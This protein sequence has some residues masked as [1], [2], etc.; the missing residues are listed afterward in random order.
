MVQ[1]LGGRKAAEL[2][3]L[4]RM[5][6]PNVEL[7]IG[8]LASIS[9]SAYMADQGLFALLVL[10]IV[11]L[12]LEHGNSRLS[13][14]G[15]VIY[16]VLL[17]AALD[18]PATGREFGQLAV[19][20][21][22]RF[23]DPMLHARV[24]YLRAG[25]IDQWTRGARAGVAELT[26]AYKGLMES[27]DWIY[28]GHCLIVR[29]WR[30]VAVGD[31]LPEILAENRRFIEFLETKKDPDS[32]QM[33]LG[34]HRTLLALTGAEEPPPM[35]AATGRGTRRQAYLKLAAAER[36]YLLRQPAEAL[37][38]AEEMVPL[39]PLHLGPLPRGHACLLP[40]AERGRGLRG[41][42]RGAEEG[43]ARR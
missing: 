20:L 3:A 12:S 5:R 7:S 15:Y 16:G 22:A 28:A 38:K 4:P 39:L 24:R 32:L 8:L 31:P 30:R 21:S 11:R 34:A 17:A 25:L 23:R 43:A 41:G 27:G 2:L 42:E 26:E 18:D 14:F 35:P 1:R 6:D 10:R 13:A 37:A 29:L 9:A 33:F 19:E 40:R 36:H